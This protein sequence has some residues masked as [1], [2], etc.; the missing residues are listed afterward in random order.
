M[1]SMY[2]L[3]FVLIALLQSCSSPL[4][5]KKIASSWCDCIKSAE[6]DPVALRDCD[7]L[8]TKDMN[9]IFMKKWKEVEEKKISMDTLKEYKLSMDKE[10]FKLTE[11]CGGFSV[12]KPINQQ[13]K[14]VPPGIK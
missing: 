4:S 13:N 8:A 2:F 12:S 9:V 3:F 14:M 5:T 11:E 7:A 1:K 10:M 6:N